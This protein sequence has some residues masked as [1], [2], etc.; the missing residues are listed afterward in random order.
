MESTASQQQVAGC[1]GTITQPRDWL[2][3]DSFRVQT[4]I[5]LRPNLVPVHWVRSSFASSV[6]RYPVA[7]AD[8][9]S[10]LPYCSD[11]PWNLHACAP[12]TGLY[13]LLGNKKNPDNANAHLLMYVTLG[14][15]YT[16]SVLERSLVVHALS[17]Y[18][19]E[20]K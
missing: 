3:Q 14:L 7:P 2:C 20:A 4:A 8:P 6:P 16:M 19:S 15:Q 11:P 13:E 1:G 18:S 5:P 12:G 17:L 9:R 10:T